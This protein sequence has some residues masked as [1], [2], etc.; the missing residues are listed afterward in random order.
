MKGLIDQQLLWVF[1]GMLTLLLV[2]TITAHVIRRRVTTQT[3]RASAQNLVA[4]I[5]SWWV[6]CIVFFL[7]L[8]AGGGWLVTLFA[9]VSLLALREYLTVI[10]TRRADHRILLWTFFIITPLQYLLIWIGWYGLFSIMIPV[11]A[12]LLIPTR[13]VLSGNTERFLERAAEI[14]WGSMICV[15]SLSH[16]PAL[17]ILSIPGYETRDAKLLLYLLL[18]DQLSDVLQYCWG[19]LLGRRPIAPQIS[20]N[21]TWEGFLGGVGSATVIGAALWWITPFQPWAA[22]ALALV[23]ALAGFAGGLTMSAIKRDRG[24]KDY[25]DLIGGHGGILDRIDSLCFAAPPFFHL[26]RYLFG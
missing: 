7:F 13:I 5:R 26:T 22:A 4:R 8:V 20:P 17:L 10:P 11:F 24:V 14:Q 21:K 12:F 16:A 2:S 19:K 18:V 9:L 15:Y 3:G 23:I 1:L 6:I 25:G